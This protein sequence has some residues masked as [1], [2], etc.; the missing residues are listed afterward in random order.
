MLHVTSPFS[1]VASSIGIV[2][3][4]HATAHAMIELAIV[5]VAQWIL[6]AR[7]STQ[8]PN[9]LAQTMLQEWNSS[10]VG[11]NCC[12]DKYTP[13][14]YYL[15]A[16]LPLPSVHLIL[17]HPTHGALS[18]ANVSE[19]HSL[20]NVARR[21][22]PYSPAMLAVIHPVTLVEGGSLWVVVNAALKRGGMASGELEMKGAQM[23]VTLPCFLPCRHSP[24]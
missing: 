2:E 21:V 3:G 23:D 22:A 11:K 17:V 15:H 12:R 16:I 19:P 20:V 24:V 6:G 18:V 8:E 5:H 7:H 1:L 14:R 10:I 9:V 13:Q 4:A